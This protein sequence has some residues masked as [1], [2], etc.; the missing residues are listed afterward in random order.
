MEEPS[1][2]DHIPTEVIE[3]DILDTEREV[4]QYEI[5]VTALEKNRPDNRLE[6][7]VR[8]GKTRQGKAFISNLKSILK[9]R[10]V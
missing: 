1:K 3:Q 2:Y 5:E 9:Y 6:L 8:E 4:N 10:K 7:Y